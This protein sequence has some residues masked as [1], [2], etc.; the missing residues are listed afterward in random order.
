MQLAFNKP[1]CAAVNEFTLHTATRTKTLD[2]AGR[3]KL[4]RYVLRLPLAQE[5]I[6][7][8]Q[9]GLVRIVLTPTNPPAN[10]ARTTN[11]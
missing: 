5:R 10:H 3:K 2:T 1:L 4:L 9:G 7:S 11:P 6:E 8:L